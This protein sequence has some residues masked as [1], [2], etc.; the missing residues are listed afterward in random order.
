MKPNRKTPIIG[1]VV[2]IVLLLS[3][4]FAYCGY[5]VGMNRAYATLAASRTG[6]AFA[7]SANINT[8]LYS[9]VAGGVGFLIG[10]IMLAL[11]IRAFRRAGLAAG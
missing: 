5:R 7:I 8:M 4:L 9:I 2:G 3:P 6:D 11:S 10:I 1:I